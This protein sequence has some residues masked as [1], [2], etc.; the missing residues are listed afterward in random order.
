MDDITRGDGYVRS[1][2]GAIDSSA[3][4]P[5]A[6]LC[7]T[8]ARNHRCPGSCSNDG[9]HHSAST[10]GTASNGHSNSRN[11]SAGAIRRASRSWII[12]IRSVPFTKPRQRG[13]A[14]D[15]DD[16]VQVDAEQLQLTHC[17]NVGT[18]AV[19]RRHPL[20]L[21]QLVER[22]RVTDAR[23]VAIDQE[24]PAVVVGDQMRKALD[25]TEG[26]NEA[27][28]VAQRVVGPGDQL[29]RTADGS[30]AGCS[31]PVRASSAAIAR[32]SICWP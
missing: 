13:E 10:S 29:R 18:L 28:D 27:V 19:E 6:Q 15:G 9:C 8:I 20:E 23:V 7:A 5:T 30:A 31:A 1:L 3:C 17:R 25:E 32:P 12:V 2:R 11:S 4:D 14:L 16:H 24:D 22:D 26:Q 21:R